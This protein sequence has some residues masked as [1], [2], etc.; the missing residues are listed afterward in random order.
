MS[1]VHEQIYILCV[2]FV[3]V[4]LLIYQAIVQWWRVF[5]HWNNYTIHFLIGRVWYI[6]GCSQWIYKIDM[7]F[8]RGLTLHVVI[9]VFPIFW[10]NRTQLNIHGMWYISFWWFRCVFLYRFMF[11][12]KIQLNSICF[13]EIICNVIIIYFYN[14]WYKGICLNIYIYGK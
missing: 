1:I 8:L 3:V 7:N 14:E 13:C 4:W 11:S 6:S 9:H 5:A 10:Q 2:S 12:H